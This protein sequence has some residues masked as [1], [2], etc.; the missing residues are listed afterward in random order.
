VLTTDHELHCILGLRA[1]YKNSATSIFRGFARA[2]QF[3]WQPS[4]TRS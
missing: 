3:R 2:P 1:G 4:S